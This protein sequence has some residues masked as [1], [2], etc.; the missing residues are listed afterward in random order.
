VGLDEREGEGEV[1][2]LPVPPPP[3]KAA[4]FDKEGVRERVETFQ[5]WVPPLMTVAVPP[6]SAPVGVTRAGVREPPSLTLEEGVPPKGGV[7]VA[8]AGVAVPPPPPI[9][10]AVPVGEGPSLPLPAP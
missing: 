2:G 5:V 7:A 1:E 3:G 8:H 6:P 10:K 4:P 9:P